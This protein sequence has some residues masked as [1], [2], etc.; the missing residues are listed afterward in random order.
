MITT[1][2]L[3]WYYV[4]YDMM[5]TWPSMGPKGGPAAAIPAGIFVLNLELWSILSATF[6]ID[7]SLA[8]DLDMLTNRNWNIYLD[9]MLYVIIFYKLYN[10]SK[11]KQKSH[12]LG[13]II[14]FVNFDWLEWFWR[15][16][17][18]SCIP[19]N[20]KYAPLFNIIYQV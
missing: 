3:L 14:I 11:R 13:Q 1:P 2:I 8:T 9:L 4:S 5:H 15:F 18:D 7:L 20:A 16:N 10:I 6:F 19:L 12:F 17:Y